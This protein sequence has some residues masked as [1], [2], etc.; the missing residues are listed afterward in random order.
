MGW[1]IDTRARDGHGEICMFC[2]ELSDGNVTGGLGEG[3]I[4]GICCTVWA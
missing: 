2:L 4:G 3:E 1:H